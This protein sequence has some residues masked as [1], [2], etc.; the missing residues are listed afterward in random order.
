[1]LFWWNKLAEIKFFFIYILFQLLIILT[2]VTKCYLVLVNCNN[3]VIKGFVCVVETAVISRLSEGRAQ[4]K[5][6]E[7]KLMML[8]WACDGQLL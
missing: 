6:S 4:V 1:M 5:S 7:S 2:K 8:H 3:P